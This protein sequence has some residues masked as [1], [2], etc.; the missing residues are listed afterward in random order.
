M[1]HRVF[2][3]KVTCQMKLSGR[4]GERFDKLQPALAVKK[5]CGIYEYLPNRPTVQQ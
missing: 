5:R 2:S 3:N 4:F 1:Q